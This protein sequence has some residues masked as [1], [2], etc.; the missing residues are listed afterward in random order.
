ML[1]IRVSIERYTDDWFPGFVECTLVDALGRLHLFEE[2]VPIVTAEPLNAKSLY[3]REGFI[4][5][6][7]IS[8]ERAADGRE[9]VT[10]DTEEPWGIESKTGETRFQVF[11]EQLV[12][13]NTSAG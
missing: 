3:P 11:R 7:L 13:N 6:V 1:E 2:K 8:E 12:E 10:V 9:I 5:C 4:A